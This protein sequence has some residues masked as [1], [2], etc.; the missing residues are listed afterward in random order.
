MDIVVLIKQVPEIDKIKFD[1]ENGTL[2]RSS[3][4][5]ETNPFDLNA[6]EA[7]VPLANM[8]RFV[9]AINA[10]AKRFNANIPLFGHAGGG[11]LHLHVIKVGEA[12]RYHQIKEEVYRTAVSLGGVITG[13]LGVGK[14]RVGE[15][16]LNLDGVA[17]NLMRG[18]KKIFDPNN[19]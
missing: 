12:S 6:L 8:G 9:D 14:D 7:A 5:V 16:V 2:D 11:N 4:G 19:I 3:A 10:I 15:I 18:I 1:I 17:V 13:E